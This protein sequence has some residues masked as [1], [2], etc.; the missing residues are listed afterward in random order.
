M[1]KDFWE[2]RYK[3]EQ[4]GWDIGEVSTPIKEFIDQLKDKELKILIPGAGNS[5][6]AEYLFCKGFKNIHVLDLASKPLQ[7]LKKRIPEFP[8]ENLYQTNFFQHSGEYDLILEQTFFCALEPK[9]RASYAEKMA[10]LL[11]PNG[12]I[13]GVLFNFEF[14]NDGPP[15]GGSTDEYL[16]YF[17]PYFEIEILEECY[18]SI[19]PR[20]GNELFFKFRKKPKK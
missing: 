17:S 8:F 6:E 18:N 15:F 20:D 16:T 19:P 11:E 14:K 12:I 4:T 10:E 1:N 2:E 5:Y 13:T 3:N 7:N 9:I